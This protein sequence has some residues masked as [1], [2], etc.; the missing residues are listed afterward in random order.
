M[1][2]PLVY[3]PSLLD[4]GRG[5]GAITTTCVCAVYF[6]IIGSYIIKQNLVGYYLELFLNYTPFPR[7]I[8]RQMDNEKV[9]AAVAWWEEAHTPGVDGPERTTAPPRAS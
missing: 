6:R 1:V 8:A 7:A 3:L 9:G 5:L 4:C 2:Y